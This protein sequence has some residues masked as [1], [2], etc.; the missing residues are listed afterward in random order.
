MDWEEP[1]KKPRAEIALGE[2]LDTWSVAE[3]EAR[4]AALEAEIART[5]TEIAAK[6]AHGAAADALFKKG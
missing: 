5:R 4:I 3:L 1:R 6:K 2:K